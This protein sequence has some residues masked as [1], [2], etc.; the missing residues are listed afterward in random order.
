MR[1]QGF[2]DLVVNCN[3]MTRLLETLVQ[4]VDDL[5]LLFT[6]STP[7][8]NF[9]Y[10]P[11]GEALSGAILDT[12]NK[13]IS[14]QIVDGGEAH[15]PKTKANGVV[16]PRACFLHYENCEDDVHHL[17]KLVQQLVAQLW[18]RPTGTV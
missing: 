7:T 15:V 1:R 10:V 3:N 17:V 11:T 8:V 4:E 18:W 6:A 9:R 5:V 16:S 2:R 12:I 14:G 13:Q